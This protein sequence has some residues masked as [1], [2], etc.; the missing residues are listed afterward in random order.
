MTSSREHGGTLKTIS[1][2]MTCQADATDRC[3]QVT[4]S[5][6]DRTLAVLRWL[7]PLAIVAYLVDDVRRQAGFE[8]IWY[9]AS[10]WTWLALALFIF[11]AAQLLTIARWYWLVR[12]LGLPFRWNDAVRLGFLGYLLTFVSLGAVGGDLLKA[13]FVAREQ[14]GRRVEAF[15]T[16]LVD[17]V[18]GLY[19]L[20][21]LAAGAILLNG[22]LWSTAP[23]A[24][25]VLGQAVLCITAVATMS[26]PLM[27]VMG[28][29]GVRSPRLLPWTESF[30][31]VAAGLRPLSAALIAYRRDPRTV[32]TSIVVGLLSQGLLAGC[33]WAIASGLVPDAPSIGEHLMIMPLAMLTTMLPLPG[34]GLG[35]F[36]FAVEFLYR[37][38]GQAPAGAGLLVALGFRLVMI[39]MAVVSAVIYAA[40]RRE[41]GDVLRESEAVDRIPVGV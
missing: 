39:A 37:H 10:N 16:V 31:K 17:R 28:N 21:L 24:M 36:E 13:L 1:L 15:A 30:P 2:E 40:N 12:A 20:L 8:Q 19:S 26:V 34:Y 29:S 5:L 35:A 23:A 11:L 27:L 38:I 4:T 18:L 33:M 7:V 41:V 6:K 3:L 22:P 25:S 32:V 14:P 9:G